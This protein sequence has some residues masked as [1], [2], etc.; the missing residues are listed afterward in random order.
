MNGEEWRPVA[1]F[2]GYQVSSRGRILS[3]RRKKQCVL[4]PHPNQSGYLLVGMINAKG[5]H[6]TLAVHRVVAT[7][8]LGPLPV[9]METCHNDGDKTNN[10][11][12]NL[13]FD[14]KSANCRDRVLHGSD[15]NARKTHCDFGHAFTPDNIYS[16]PSRPG[17]RYCRACRARYRARYAA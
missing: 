3:A 15:R 11:A 5:K 4:A 17:V 14:T 16:P 9:G 13:R 10:A 1:G 8:F 2:P 7:A 12:S 6:R